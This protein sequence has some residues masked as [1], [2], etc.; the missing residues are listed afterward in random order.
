MRARIVVVTCLLLLAFHAQGRADGT[1]TCEGPPECCVPAVSHGAKHPVAVGIV[2]MGISNINERTAT[3]DAD[4]YLYEEWTPAPGFTPQTEVVNEVTRQST[5]GDEVD[6]RDGKCLRSR[7]IH[8]SLG[9]E[10]NLR[11][12]PFDTQEL[13]LE[14]SD[15][16][17]TSAEL[18]YE[19]KPY[20]TGFDERV[21]RMMSN[22]KLYT[23]PTYAHRSSAFTWERGAPAYD[24]AT[25]KFTVRRHVTFHLF[26]FFLPLLV[27]VAL[28]FSVFWIDPDDLGAPAGIGVTCLLAAIAF[29]FAEQSSL[30]E[31]SYLTLADR[32]YVVCYLAIGSALVETIWTNNLAR[33]GQRERAVR[34]D[35]R[36]RA[37]FPAAVILALCASTIRAF[38]EVL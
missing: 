13:V 17:F 23:E 37:L 22:W 29:Q 36:C 27:I 38:T 7:R 19:D 18:A 8:S 30:P 24:Y 6:L 5:A 2:I 20:A 33:R 28:A 10:Y 3:W 25:V 15:N 16:E 21:R 1:R 9:A 34:I 35:R 11:R 14:L 12:F 32:V 31:I 4:Y 26:K